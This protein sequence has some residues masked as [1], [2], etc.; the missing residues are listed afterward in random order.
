MSKNDGLVFGLT[1]RAGGRIAVQVE[2][3]LPDDVCEWQA[4]ACFSNGEQT[5]LRVVNTGPRSALVILAV[6]LTS[7]Y[8]NV[9]ALDEEG[10]ILA[11]GQYVA[12]HHPTKVLSRANAML[13]SDDVD[14]MRVI[15][16][17][18]APAFTDVLVIQEPYAQNVIH[19][20]LTLEGTS[21]KVADEHVHIDAI[22]VDG[23]RI[24][25]SCITIVGDA[26]REGDVAGH[27]VRLIRVSVRISAFLEG[28]TLWAR[29][30]SGQFDGF[31]VIEPNV[32]RDRRIDAASV[33]VPT[34]AAANYHR[35]FVGHRATSD[36]LAA[37]RVEQQSFAIRPTFSVVIPLWHTPLPFLRDVVDSVLA[38]SYPELELILVNSTPEDEDLA[39]EVRLIA[40]RDSRVVVVPLEENL[41]ITENTNAGIAAATGDFVSF[42]DH[43]DIIERD[44]FY[45]YVRG[46]NDYP[47]TDLLYCDEDLLV[48]GYYVNPLFKPD[49]SMLYL[50]S[51]NYVCH[52]LTVR[53]SIIDELPVPTRELDGAQDHS[54][55]LA[56]GERA[57]NVYHARRVLY[58]WRSHP[59]STAGNPDVKP[60]SF[61]AG[62]LAIERH[63]ERIGFEGTC[64]PSRRWGHVFEMWPR[65]KGTPR[66]TAI[67]WGDDT[68]KA[69]FGVSE[70]LELGCDEV[71]DAGEQAGSTWSERVAKAMGEAHGD[72]VL[73]LGRDVRPLG[74]DWLVTLAAYVERADV[75][76]VAPR[77]LLPDGIIEGIGMMCTGEQGLKQTDHLRSAY[78][79]LGR[80]VVDS[81]HD[82]T[83]CDPR[84]ILMRRS[85]L[86]ELGGWDESFSMEYASADYCLRVRRHGE[87]VGVI[88]SVSA[89]VLLTA[90]EMGFRTGAERVGRCLEHVRF[91]SKWPGVA[92]GDPFYHRLHVQDGG[93]SFEGAWE[94]LIPPE[95]IEGLKRK[96]LY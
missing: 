96:L 25:P 73:L 58:H 62:Q 14:Q 48:D 17:Q 76:V 65:L 84:C 27:Y 78:T 42:L 9:R 6:F 72:Q 5:P 90:S 21:A 81:P 59:L 30:Q 52:L 16:G 19:A 4:Q 22:G 85:L 51:N 80:Y 66:I 34:E 86:E 32:M 20:T 54:M 38:Q 11:R 8:L 47:T 31:G 55:T 43:D 29:L 49:W 10:N 56:V 95:P 44:L 71:L 57:R 91:V 50:E 79:V 2:S 35:W 53:K 70:W 3:T 87:A 18:D 67:L 24:S 41:G 63:Y 93:Y 83:T 15:L 82:M 88:S 13:H 33:N 64:V 77:L 92:S 74:T 7:Q 69:A 94:W 89:E 40:K 75:G 36:M 46:I 26:T 60:E 37:Q 23:A 61:G 12:R 45:W 1:C 68:T 39:D 28:L